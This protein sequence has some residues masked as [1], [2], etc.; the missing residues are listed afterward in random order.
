MEAGKEEVEEVV[1]VMAE[2]E[3]DERGVSK[4]AAWSCPAARW[5]PSSAAMK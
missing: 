3:E 5:K 2:E 4:E 1:V